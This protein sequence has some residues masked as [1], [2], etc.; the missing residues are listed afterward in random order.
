[1]ND[2]FNSLQEDI[3][4]LNIKIKELKDYGFKKAEAEEI[5]RIALSKYLAERL[6]EGQKVSILGDLARGDTKIANLRKNRDKW[7]IMYDTT[8]ES[9]YSLKTSI[10]IQETMLKLEYGSR[11]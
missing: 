10:R 9:V 6:L 7:Q 8:L 3:K 4:L 11:E 2:L 1:M 5:Y